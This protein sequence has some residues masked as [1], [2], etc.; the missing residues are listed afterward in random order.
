MSWGSYDFVN[1]RPKF[2]Y[3]QI[4]K[5]E[6]E[7]SKT[8]FQT[9][10][11]HYEYLVMSFGLSNTPSTFQALMNQVLRPYLRKFILVF[12]DI[13][14]IYSKDTKSHVGHLWE[15]LHMLKRHRLLANKKCSFAQ[16]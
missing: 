12:F 16:P 1:D 10:E 3:H 7:I 8:A 15:V 11:G 14:L 13:I 2:G 9:H 5:K 6:N 4:R